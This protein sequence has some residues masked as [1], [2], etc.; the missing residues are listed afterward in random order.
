MVEANISFFIDLT[1]A[2]DG[3]DPYKKMVEHEACTLGMSVQYERHPIVDV[4]IPNEP[5]DMIRI[6][7]AIDHAMDMGRSVYVHCW[8]GVGRTGTVVGCWLVR[9]GSTGDEALKRIAQLWQGVEK[10]T[11]IPYS[12]ETCEQREYVRNWHE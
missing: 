7:D 5:Q 9:H 11:R 2:K 4:S 10:V 3:L 8:G 1:E 6:L 12:P